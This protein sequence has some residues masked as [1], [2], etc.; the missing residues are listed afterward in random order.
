M[1]ERHIEVIFCFLTS[2][3]FDFGEVPPKYDLIEVEK[4]IFQE[5]V[6]HFEL[7]F[8]LLIRPKCDLVEVEK[9]MFQGLEW[10]SQLNS[11]P[12]L[13]Q[14]ANLLKSKKR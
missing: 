2:P 3:K 7:I 10:H 11:A 5:L 1:V 13:A 8:G 14:N 6:C 12:G 4:A 9:A